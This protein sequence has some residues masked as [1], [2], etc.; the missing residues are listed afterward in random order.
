[1][2]IDIVFMAKSDK[3]AD[4]IKKESFINKLLELEF[5]KG[6]NKSRETCSDEDEDLNGERCYD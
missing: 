1:M 2:I 3:K 6:K 4:E 5:S